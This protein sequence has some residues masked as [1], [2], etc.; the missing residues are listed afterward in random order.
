MNIFGAGN[1]KDAIIQS[2]DVPERLLHFSI[3]K[4][5]HADQTTKCI[6]VKLDQ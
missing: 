3:Q 5:D 2:D 1:I 4:S 6:H